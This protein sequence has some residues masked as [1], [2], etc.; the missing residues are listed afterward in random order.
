LSGVVITIYIE[1]LDEGVQAWRPV[2][3]IHEGGCVYRLPQRRPPEMTGEVWAFPPGSLVVCEVRDFSDNEGPVPV[4]VRRADA[5]DLH[6]ASNVLATRSGIDLLIA[7]GPALAEIVGAVEAVA[8]IPPDAVE[9]PDD[10][11][12]KHLVILDNPAWA[13]IYAFEAGDF[14][15]KV[16][17]DGIAPRDYI[18]IARQLTHV[19]KVAI[20]WP[21]ETTLAAN[22]FTICYADGTEYSLTLH[23]CEPDGFTAAAL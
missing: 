20:V 9:L 3:A 21:D 1:L 16:D 8:G 6:S 17:L 18:A 19:L 11:R 12:T 23:D 7:R 2:S 4:A 5:M 22:A 15:Y 10:A 14:G 13:V